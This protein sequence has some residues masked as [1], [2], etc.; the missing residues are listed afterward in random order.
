MFSK[1]FVLAD[2]LKNIDTFEPPVPKPGGIAARARQ[3]A[4]G[5]AAYLE[6]LNPEQLEA[7]ESLDGPVLVLAGAG[8]GK[9]R[10]LTAQ[11]TESG[12]SDTKQRG[13]RRGPVTINGKAVERS[14]AP[15]TFRLGERV[16]HQKFGYGKISEVDGG[17]LTVQFDKAGEKRVVETFVE[18][19]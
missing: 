3:A 8:T 18:R 13:F 16:F 15:R 7:V 14:A 4:N 9:T 17:K 5:N 12:F 1:G 11:R 6:G 10:V 2:P 19:A